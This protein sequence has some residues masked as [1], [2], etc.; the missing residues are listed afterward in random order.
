MNAPQDSASARRSWLIRPS[1][2][3]KCLAAAV[4]LM[5]QGQEQRQP[6]I[7]ARKRLEPVAE[8]DPHPHDLGRSGIRSSTINSSHAPSSV[9][10]RSRRSTRKALPLPGVAGEDLAGVEPAAH[11]AAFIHLGHGI[12]GQNGRMGRVQFAPL[13]QPGIGLA[14]I[15]HG[16]L[17][18]VLAG[19][20]PKIRGIG[21]G[22]KVL[23]K[24]LW[25]DFP[26]Q[27]FCYDCG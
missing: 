16:L 25:A 24:S 6:A 7:P 12:A 27:R 10:K 14:G 8:I 17:D 20:G 23:S 4:V 22:N 11:L 15:G 13:G 2:T 18:R 1:P 19:L 5:P 21:Q 3:P 26:P 9:S